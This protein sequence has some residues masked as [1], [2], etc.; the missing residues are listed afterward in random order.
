MLPSSTN[1]AMSLS[2]CDREAALMDFTSIRALLTVSQNQ[3]CHKPCISRAIQTLIVALLLLRTVYV[4]PLSSETHSHSQYL[5]CS[6]VTTFC[7]LTRDVRLANP[8]AIMQAARLVIL[9]V[10]LIVSSD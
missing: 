7:K 8:Y 5:G 4:S 9:A 3:K 6:G 10:E 2:I 1:A